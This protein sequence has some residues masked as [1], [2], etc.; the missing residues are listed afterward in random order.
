MKLAAMAAAI[1]NL[2]MD[3]FSLVSVSTDGPGT[4]DEARPAGSST[5]GHI[6]V[7]SVIPTGVDRSEA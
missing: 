3:V 2:V 1:M 4:M 6:Q 7:T 5:G